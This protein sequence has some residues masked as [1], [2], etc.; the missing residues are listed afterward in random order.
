VAIFS[1]GGQAALE[2]KNHD[3]VAAPAITKAIDLGVN[4]IDTSSIYGGPER[5][6]ERYVGQ[7]MKERRAEA[8]LASKT[9]ERTRD[10]SLRMLDESLKLLQTNQLDLWQLH[11]VGTMGEARKQLMTLPPTVAVA[12]M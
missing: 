5:W 7:V 12:P 11:D 3:E 8:F 2:I 9:K 1:L 4:Y 10:A 6:S